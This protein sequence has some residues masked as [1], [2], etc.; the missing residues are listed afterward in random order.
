MIEPYQA[1]GGESMAEK[2]G[3]KW[4]I[5]INNP[6]DRGL[7]HGQIKLALDSIR[8]LEYFCLSDEIGLDTHTPHTHLFLI[9]KSPAR[10]TRL[11]KLFPEA[12]IEIA[13]GSGEENRAYVER[14]LTILSQIPAFPVLLRNGGNCQ[15]SR[16]KGH[17]R[18]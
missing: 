15:T 16:D 7:D 5:T 1:E 10:F 6:Q 9:L 11:K 3:R 4:Q 14:G 2:Q 17:E 8:N 18:T 13:R 12:H